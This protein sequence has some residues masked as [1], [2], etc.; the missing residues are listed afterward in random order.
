M[1]NRNWFWGIFLLLAAV[2]AVGSQVGAFNAVNFWTVAATVLL[3]AIL[4]DSLVR[5]SFF[6]I[7]I[8]VALLYGLYCRP[9]GWPNISV[10]LLLLAA[11]LASWGLEILFGRHRRWYDHCGHCWHDWHDK[12]DGEHFHSNSEDIDGDTPSAKISFGSSSKYLHSSALKSGRF[13]VAF[14]ELDIY[15]DQVQLSPEGAE[16]F[17]ECSFGKMA[18]FIPRSWQV[19]DNLRASAGSVQNDMRR[20]SPEPGAPHLTLSGSASFGTIEIHY[21]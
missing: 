1:K 13:S 2:F 11:V 4:V 7:L 10:W 6:G 21:I 20:E 9:F 3:A 8:P 15:F 16:I 18:L 14:G 12:G 17:A 5:L 19:T